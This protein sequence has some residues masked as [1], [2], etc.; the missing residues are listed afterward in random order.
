MRKIIK[1]SKDKST[2]YF[3]CLV[4]EFVRLKN[5]SRISGCWFIKSVIGLCPETV[6]EVP[7]NGMVLIFLGITKHRKC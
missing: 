2:I 6:C 7:V 1:K 3:S 5:L 4:R